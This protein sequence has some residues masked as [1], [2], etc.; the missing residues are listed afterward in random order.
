MEWPAA[1]AD[2]TRYLSVVAN[3]VRKAIRDGRTMREA[4]ESVGNE[5]RDNWLLFD[6]YHKRNVSAAFAELEW[7]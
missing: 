4:M 5:E 2:I 6:D 3:G 1:A 7:E